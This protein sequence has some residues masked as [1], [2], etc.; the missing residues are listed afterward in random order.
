MRDAEFRREQAWTLTRP[1][2]WKR[3]RQSRSQT[4]WPSDSH[5]VRP[6]DTQ[7]LTQSDSLAVRESE[8]RTV[9]IRYSD[10]QAVWDP[11][12]PRVRL[13]NSQTDTVRQTVNYYRQSGSECLDWRTEQEHTDTW[14]DNVKIDFKQTS[15][16]F[17]KTATKLKRFLTQ[18]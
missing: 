2:I 18:F 3:G 13:S 10:S 5:N 12:R 16:I 15:T 6:S 7:A 8:S 4:V 11:E 14:T 9:M 17:L 1:W